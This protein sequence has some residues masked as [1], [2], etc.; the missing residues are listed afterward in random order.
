MHAARV[1]LPQDYHV[2]LQYGSVLHEDGDGYR[3]CELSD[4]VSNGV[5]DELGGGKGELSDGEA[6]AL[7]GVAVSL[8]A[9]FLVYWPEE[10]VLGSWRQ[11]RALREER[12]CTSSMVQA[13]TVS[14]SLVLGMRFQSKGTWWLR[15]S[16]RDMFTVAQH[17]FKF[18]EGLQHHQTLAR[19][20]NNLPPGTAALFPKLPSIVSVI[21]AR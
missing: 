4:E 17:E 3:V 20:L 11:E 6:Y 8:F 16:K 13:L 21:R 10:V 14:C 12:E 5:C 9:G 7:L 19:L 18:P 1:S 15:L 2:A